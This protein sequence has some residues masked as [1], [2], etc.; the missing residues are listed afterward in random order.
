MKEET[1]DHFILTWTGT[2]D[3]VPSVFT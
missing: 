2:E 1:V 3:V